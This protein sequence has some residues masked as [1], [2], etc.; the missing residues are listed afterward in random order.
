MGTTRRS[1]SVPG[2][3][4]ERLRSLALSKGM[5]I[6]RL[7][8]DA[9]NELCD[10]SSVQEMTIHEAESARVQRRERALKEA[11][12]RMPPDLRPRPKPDLGG[13]VHEF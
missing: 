4:Y 10:K 5:P 7:V 9:L 1:I 12:D 13:G 8:T 6:S 2:N 3:T 11:L